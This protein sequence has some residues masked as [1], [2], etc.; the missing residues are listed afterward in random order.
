MK[1]HNTAWNTAWHDRK[2]SERFAA[3]WT[4][5][6]KSTAYDLNSTAAWMNQLAI[7][8]GQLAQSMIH[9]E[10]ESLHPAHLKL[11]Q[12][13]AL[14]LAVHAAKLAGSLDLAQREQDPMTADNTAPSASPLAAAVPNLGGSPQTPAMAPV[15]HRGQ[16]H[17]TPLPEPVPRMAD[18]APE[19]PNPRLPRAATTTLAAVAH[20]MNS[21][22]G[23]GQEK[24]MDQTIASL[25]GRG[26]SVDEIEL[27]T[28][29]PRNLIDS[30]LKVG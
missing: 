6:D 29:Q 25:Y 1:L 19:P 21:P 14:K 7:E 16:S 5:L 22:S 17:L 18:I 13:K 20:E 12:D 30:I 9:L 28:G 27:V 10:G 3:E 15:T 23:L 24:S 4:K 2:L 26:L 11:A 8:M